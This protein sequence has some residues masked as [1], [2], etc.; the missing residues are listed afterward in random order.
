MNWAHIH[1]LLNHV[2]VLG[3]VFGLG[4]LAYAITRRSDPLKRAAFNMFVAVALVALP[5]YFTGEPAEEVVEETP[6]SQV[7]IDAHEDSAL[8]SLI[9][10]EVLGVVALAGLVIARR[11]RPV[12][13]KITGLTLAVSLATAIAM[14]WTANLGG[15]IRHP[16]I[17]P[18]AQPVTTEHEADEGR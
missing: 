6:V 14:A 9:G 8:M 18:G 17:G 10:V 3:T 4:L 7:T 15:R 12:S 13:P 1:L 2:P 16:E 5:V 11:G